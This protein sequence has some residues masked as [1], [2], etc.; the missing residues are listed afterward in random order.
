MADLQM[1]LSEA[2]KLNRSILQFLK[3]SIYTDYDDLS[4]LDIDRTDSEQLLLWEEL[5]RITDKLADVQEYVSYL[6]RPI[7]EVSILRKGTAGKYRTAKGHFYDCRSSIEALVT[8]EYHEVPYWT[9]TVVEH[10]RE[11]YYLVGYKDLPMKGL[12]VRVRSAA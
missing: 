11:D 7:T 12:R 9:R 10:N 6:T 5:R 1:V 4:G 3:F 8:D 2:V